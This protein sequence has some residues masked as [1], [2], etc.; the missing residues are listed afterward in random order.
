MKNRIAIIDIGTN[1][2]NLL[3]VDRSVDSFEIVFK[4]RVGVG[5]G[6]NGI[7]DA[8][9]ASC[10]FE[11]GIKTLENFNDRCLQLNVELVHA[12]GTSA[13][14]NA[15]NKDAFLEEV[16]LKTGIHIR[17]ISGAEEAE[18]IFKGVK[19]G[20]DFNSP[21][22]IMDI[23]GGS[24]EFI[25][26][27]H[28]GI[29]QKKSFEIGVSRMYQ[30]F[31]KPKELDESIV[32]NIEGYLEKTTK[33]FFKNIESSVFIGSSGSFKTFYELYSNK[34]YPRNEYVEIEIPTLIKSLNQIIYST[35]DERYR[36][37]F[38]IPIRKK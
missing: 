5:L 9:I 35:K 32:K 26:A 7:N 21:G 30:Y 36:N 18:Y 6:N 23:G 38:I 8:K 11:R 4:E 13:L 33:D 15:V 20:Y 14:R 27:N 10:A 34:Q 17:V 1:T 19:L 31:D 28:L 22:L 16:A 24:T 37:D 2:F 25:Y 12:F 3:V 29:Q